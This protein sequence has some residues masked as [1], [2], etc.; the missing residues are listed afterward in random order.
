M[1]GETH[2]VPPALPDRLP[3][4]A[5]GWSIRRVIGHGTWQLAPPRAQSLVR[6]LAWTPAAL[7]VTTIIGITLATRA[8]FF[9][10]YLIPKAGLGK[11]GFVAGAG[12]AMS[13]VSSRL[14]AW[15]L[16]RLASA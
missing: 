11:L 10:F 12:A 13:R 6:A 15:Y 16:R 7:I 3:A 4:V 5:G 1:S 14:T 2:L 9:M 8:Q